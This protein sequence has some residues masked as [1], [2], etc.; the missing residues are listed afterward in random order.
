[1]FLFFNFMC[2]ERNL[3]V[4][5]AAE[6]EEEYLTRKKERRKENANQF[7]RGCFFLSFFLSFF[8][9]FFFLLYVSS[10]LGLVLFFCFFFR[11]VFLFLFFLLFR[12][13]ERDVT[14]SQ[15]FLFLG[16]HGK[17]EGFERKKGAGRS[18]A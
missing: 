10:C 16:Y 1:M 2:M 4:C 5:L 8:L 12:F 17:K 3:V 15:F 11:L 6:E 14:M 9:F 13:G 18:L 7:V